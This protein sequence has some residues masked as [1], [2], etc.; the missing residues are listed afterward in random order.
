MAEVREGPDIRTV[1]T[2]SCR[3]C[4][5]L[6]SS[7]YAVQGDS[8]TDYSCGYPLLMKLEPAQRYI[9][10]CK[11]DTPSWCPVPVPRVGRG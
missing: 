7:S 6:Q 10:D 2:R 1:T 11:T 5:H 4:M 3:G 8:G 9:G